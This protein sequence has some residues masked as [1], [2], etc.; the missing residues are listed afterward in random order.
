[1]KIYNLN[2]LSFESNG[3]KGNYPKSGTL[4]KCRGQLGICYTYT[5]C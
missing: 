3:S 1:M 4:V 2:K 5:T